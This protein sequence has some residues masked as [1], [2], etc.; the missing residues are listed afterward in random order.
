MIDVPDD[1]EHKN[2]LGDGPGVNEDNREII[3]SWRLRYEVS[4]Y[5]N[6]LHIG[7]GLDSLDYMDDA[8]GISFPRI[9]QTVPQAHMFF[10]K[11]STLKPFSVSTH[12]TS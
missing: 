7:E 6:G 11:S 10:L 12:N 5:H 4:T 3:K 9:L 1:V 8:L 2:G